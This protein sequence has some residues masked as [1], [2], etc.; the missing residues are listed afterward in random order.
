MRQRTKATDH[1]PFFPMAAEA[2][3]CRA[4]LEA[5]APAHGQASLIERQLKNADV[6]LGSKAQASGRP[7]VTAYDLAMLNVESRFGIARMVDALKSRGV[8]LD[9][10]L[11]AEEFLDQLEAEHRIKPEVREGRAMGFMRHDL[12]FK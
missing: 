4:P 6:A 5:V 11:S 1:Q 8:I 9:V 3:A 7:S 2:E 12:L 10:A